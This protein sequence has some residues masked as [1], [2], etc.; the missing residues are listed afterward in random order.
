MY[1]DH[2][3]A[4]RLA[5]AA[6]LGACLALALFLLSACAPVM[7]R[8][9]RLAMSTTLNVLVSGGRK[10]DWDSL[11]T[12]ADT[13]SWQFDH[14]HP[15][16]VIGRLNRDGRVSGPWPDGVRATLELARRIAEQSQGAF[17]PTVLP[18]TSLWAFD[19]GG[20]L[21][22]AAALQAA[23]PRVDYK[24]LFVGADGTVSLP[25]GFGLDLGAIAKGAV[26]DL[27][28]AE[29]DRRGHHRYL[30]EAGGDILVSG[31]KKGGQ[32]WSIGIRHPRQAEAMIGILKV[33]ESGPVSVVTSGDYERY[34][35]QGGR[36]YHHIIDPHTGYP[37]EGLV[38]VTVIAPTCASADALATAAF[39][40]GP[41]EGLELL[42]DL[43]S[44]E[45][46]LIAERGGTLIAERTSGFPLKIEDLAF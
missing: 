12:F 22:A 23:L 3:G 5:R 21:P 28:G 30:V 11:F 40:L 44:V 29:L 10:P 31:P 43:E 9:S 8:E 4:R 25:P 41:R 2:P 38:S 34:F 19:K 33:G 6:R 17:D 20:E 15:D 14:R 42:E 36:R 27:I 18:L 16:G 13:V 26:V 1:A 45:G 35:D 46:L 39:V 24:R 7:H 37:A 32:P